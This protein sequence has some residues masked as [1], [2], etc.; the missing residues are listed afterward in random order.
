MYFVSKK[1]VAT[2]TL[3]VRHSSRLVFHI[4]RWDQATSKFHFMMKVKSKLKCPQVSN[5]SKHER[6][7]MQAVCLLT[8]LKDRAEF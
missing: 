3:S 6:F 5:Y 2:P 8:C 1:V 7:L 4:T